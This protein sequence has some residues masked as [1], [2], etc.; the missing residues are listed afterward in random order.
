MDKSPD[1][2]PP[3]AAAPPQYGGPPQQMQQTTVITQGTIITQPYNN[4][5]HSDNQ[6]KAAICGASAI[7]I[8]ICLFLFGFPMFIGG[9]VA[10]ATDSR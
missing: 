9:I 2:A 4:R 3:P 1:Q 10:L 7:C 6:T 8:I 5:V